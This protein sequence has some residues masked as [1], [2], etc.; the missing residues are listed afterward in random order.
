MPTSRNSSYQVHERWGHSLPEPLER[1]LR[2]EQG[3]GQEQK[4]GHVRVLLPKSSKREAHRADCRELGDT[5][6]PSVIVMTSAHEDLFRTTQL[7]QLFSFRPGRESS[8]RV[9]FC[10]QDNRRYFRR[11]GVR[12][13]RLELSCAPVALL[14]PTSLDAGDLWEHIPAA[15]TSVSGDPPRQPGTSRRATTSCPDRQEMRADSS[16][17]SA[18]PGS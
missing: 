9:D 1:F 2:Q 7:E 17:M 4:H 12:F 8:A 5:S 11:G 15:K 10:K 6:H 18:E 14:K 16:T 13:L 3:Q